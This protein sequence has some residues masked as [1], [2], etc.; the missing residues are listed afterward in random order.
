ML[1]RRHLLRYPEPA[2]SEQA[3]EVP[4]PSGSAGFIWWRDFAAL[5]ELGAGGDSISV[6]VPAH[7]QSSCA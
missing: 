3:F 4:L 1:S 6:A 5:L 7:L 2:S